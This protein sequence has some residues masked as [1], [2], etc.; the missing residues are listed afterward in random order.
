[1]GWNFCCYWLV[2]CII[3]SI[4]SNVEI[5][6]NDNLDKGLGYEKVNLTNSQHQYAKLTKEH[7]EILSNLRLTLIEF[8][9]RLAGISKSFK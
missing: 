6:L 3:F 9:I 8:I 5:G 7:R 2:G 1:M 4:E